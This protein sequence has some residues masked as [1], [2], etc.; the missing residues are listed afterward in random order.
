MRGWAEGGGQRG[1]GWRAEGGRL[2][3]RRGEQEGRG[4]RGA[5]AA[6]RAEVC[7][8]GIVKERVSDFTDEDAI[9]QLREVAQ[10]A[11]HHTVHKHQPHALAL[12][13]QGQRSHLLFQLS[14]GGGKARGEERGEVCSPPRLVLA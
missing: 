10:L 9:R 7:R 14:R 12:P 5:G 2:E 1:G 6:K 3:R 13:L 4:P 8:R 11:A